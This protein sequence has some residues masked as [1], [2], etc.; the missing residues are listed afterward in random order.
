MAEPFQLPLFPDQAS[1]TRIRPERN[2]GRFYEGRFYRVAVWPDLFGRALLARQWGRIG[3]A[4]RLRLDPHPDP[5][6]AI[7]A[8]PQAARLPGSNVPTTGVVDVEDVRIEAR[9]GAAIT[10]LT[11][12]EIIGI[13]DA[14]VVLVDAA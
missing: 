11:T 9:D 14:E 13:E 12:V 1:L 8:G 7:N 6:A 10:D 4:A 3:T 5:G 2:E